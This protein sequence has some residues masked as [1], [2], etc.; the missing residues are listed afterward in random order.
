MTPYIC[1]HRAGKNR[2]RMV[3]G[4]VILGSGYPGKRQ[5]AIDDDI[6]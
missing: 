4:S 1:D 5:E 2:N 6:T 3:V